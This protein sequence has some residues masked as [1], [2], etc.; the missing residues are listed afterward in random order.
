MNNT[1]PRTQG[2]VWTIAVVLFVFCVGVSVTA[3][4]LGASVLRHLRY[5]TDRG[6]TAIVGVFLLLGILLGAM[7]ARRLLAAISEAKR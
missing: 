7:S 2:R 6:G 4:C 1:L 5:I 3:G